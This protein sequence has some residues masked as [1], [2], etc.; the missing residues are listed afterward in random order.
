MEIKLAS[1]PPSYDHTMMQSMPVVGQAYPAGSGFPQQPPYQQPY[2]PPPALPLHENH[3][4]DVSH[5]QSETN[6]QSTTNLN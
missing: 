2:Y 4:T 6:Q 3:P 1:A 5:Q